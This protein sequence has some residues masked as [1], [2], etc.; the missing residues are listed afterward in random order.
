MSKNCLVD[1]SLLFWF[2]YSFGE[3]LVLSQVS[4]KKV[5]AEVR[6]VRVSLESIE[7]TLESLVDALIPEEEMSQGE[8]KEIDEVEREVKRGEGVS[9]EEVRR[10]YGAKK[11]G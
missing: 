2:L 3:E 6:K 11:S 1:E 5:F 9:L 4:L 7:R 10:K 8:W